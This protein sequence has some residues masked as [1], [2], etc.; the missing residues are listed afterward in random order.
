MIIKMFLTDNA[1]TKCKDQGKVL[2]CPK[3]SE[4]LKKLVKHMGNTNGIWTGIYKRGKLVF[5]N[6]YHF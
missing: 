2:F 5:S 4:D 3:T 1:K 6:I